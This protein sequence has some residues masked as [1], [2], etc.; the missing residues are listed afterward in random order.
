[1]LRVTTL[2][3]LINNISNYS[4]GKREVIILNNRQK[5][6]ITDRKSSSLETTSSL[7][8]VAEYFT[9]FDV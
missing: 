3:P 6:L 9:T 1:M 2:W 4:T 5:H 7:Q 8:R